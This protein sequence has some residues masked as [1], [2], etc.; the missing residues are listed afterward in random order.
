MLS[1]HRTPSIAILWIFIGTIQQVLGK[2]VA[3]DE[4]KHEKWHRKE[5]V[6]WKKWSPSHKFLYVLF[7]ITQCLFLL[8]FSSGPDNI[9]AS[10][11]KSTSKKV[12]TSISEITI[13]Y[14]RKNI[15]IPPLCQSGLFIQN[16]CLKTQL[17]LKMWFFTS[18][19]IRCWAE[20]S[21]LS[22]YSFL[23]KFGK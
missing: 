20:V 2:G 15:I 4:E 16:V 6:Q 21:F 23:L 17:S 19:D 9:T 18:F 1:L 12:P 14:L 8:R 10:I 11:T 22:F 13:K 3:V 7:S 5:G